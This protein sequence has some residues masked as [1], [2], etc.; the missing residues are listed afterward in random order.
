MTNTE[1]WD[2][3]VFCNAMLFRVTIITKDGSRVNLHF[4]DWSAAKAWALAFRAEPK[5]CHD[6]LIYAVTPSG[7]CV[8]LS[9]ERW[10]H[11]QKL[12]DTSPWLAHEQRGREHAEAEGRLR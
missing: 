9:T 5:S 4:Q 8:C 3:F 1:K 6:A 12:W 10:P 2:D 11:Y 7:G